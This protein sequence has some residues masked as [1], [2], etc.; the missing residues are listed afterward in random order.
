LQQVIKSL[1]DFNFTETRLLNLFELGALYHETGR[2]TNWNWL[3][4]VQPAA[5]YLRIHSEPRRYSLDKTDWNSRLLFENH[6]FLIFQKPAQIPCHPMVDNFQEN[7]LIQLQLLLQKKLYL[8]H[9]LDIATEGLLLF[10]K[11]PEFQTHFNKALADR[12]V[13]KKYFALVEGRPP[14]SETAPVELVHHMVPSPRAPKTVVKEAQ[15]GTQICRLKILRQNHSLLEIELLTGRTHQIRAQLGHERF[16]IVGDVAYGAKT[17]PW[18][19]ENIALQAFELCFPDL[20]EN[21]IWE[22]RVPLAEKVS[23]LHQSS[24]SI[25]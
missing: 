11:T 4:D 24:Q 9:R 25:D 5:T 20:D 7:L 13:H 3:I 15:A 21:K 6:H 22:F 2:L 16:P 12:R 19:V 10:A 17:Q 18:G 8:T 23:S 14:W 1:A